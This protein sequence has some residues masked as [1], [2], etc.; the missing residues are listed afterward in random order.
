M[1]KYNKYSFS[2]KKKMSY[3]FSII[4]TKD[5]PIYELEIGTYKQS[6]DGTP[7][8]SNDIKELR[9][10]VVNSSLDIVEDLQW[11]T[12]DHYLKS[13]DNFYGYNISCFLTSGNI[14]FMMLHDTKSEES[15]RLFFTDV[16]DL[17]TKALLSP[18]YNFN[19]PIR[20]ASFDAR[21]RM[22]AKKYL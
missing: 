1:N 18:F 20:S 7:K 19:D 22:L 13:I 5:N 8:F 21:I 2:P 14:K 17:Y 6:G 4:G 16:Y 11:K 3:Y 12:T 15:L 10:F 9:Q